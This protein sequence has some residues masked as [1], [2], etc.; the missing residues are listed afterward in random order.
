MLCVKVFNAANNKPVGN[1]KVKVASG[2]GVVGEGTTDQKGHCHFSVDFDLPVKVT[3]EATRDPLSRNEKTGSYIFDIKQGDKQ[4][5]Y[6]VAINFDDNAKTIFTAPE[7]QDMPKHDDSTPL[8]IQHPPGLREQIADGQ[9]KQDKL[10]D[11]NEPKHPE[12]RPG[13]SVNHD[14]VDNQSKQDEPTSESGTQEEAIENPP[15]K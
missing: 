15:G 2:K 11:P 13:G 5:E 10:N 14:P 7:K 1:A 6:R 9:S 3:V 4:G 12:N 8:R